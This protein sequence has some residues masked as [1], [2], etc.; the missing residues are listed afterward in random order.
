MAWHSIEKPKSRGELGGQR[1]EEGI[2]DKVKKS[3]NSAGSR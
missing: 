2:R 3:K 1:E